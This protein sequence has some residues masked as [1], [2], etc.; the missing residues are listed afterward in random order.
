[1]ESILQEFG[2]LPPVFIRKLD[3]RSDWHPE[4]A[5]LDRPRR[6]ADLLFAEA[7][8]IFSLWYIKN[9]QD[10]YNMVTAI[11]AHRS[12]QNQNFDFIWITADELKDAGIEPEEFAEGQCIPARSLHYNAVISAEAAVLLCQDLLDANRQDYRCNRKKTGAILDLKRS[13]GC[14]ALVPDSTGCLCES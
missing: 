1:M 3:R 10:F 13:S 11:S 9:D 4:V 2:I 6:S 7:D 8:R 5:P 14:Y 12:P